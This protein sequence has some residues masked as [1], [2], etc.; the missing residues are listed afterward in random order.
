[1]FSRE[2]KIF[3]VICV[4]IAGF[5]SPVATNLYFPALPSVAK[6]HISIAPEE[7]KLNII[8]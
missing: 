3:I 7:R 2:K 4:S 8:I 6:V 5:F 1:V